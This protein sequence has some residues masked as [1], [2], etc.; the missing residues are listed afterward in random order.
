MRLIDAN[1]LTTH[2]YL[3]R[4]HAP[5]SSSS[6]ASSSGFWSCS[7]CAAHPGRPHRRSLA[8]LPSSAFC[9]YNTA[10]RRLLR[11]LRRER[12]T[13]PSCHQLPRSGRGGVR[14]APKRIGR[15]APLTHPAA[16]AREGHGRPARRTAG[17]RRR[18]CWL[19]GLRMVSRARTRRRRRKMEQDDTGSAG[20]SAAQQ[21]NASCR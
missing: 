3:D 17:S 16:H 8:F 11:R 18:L 19:L 14:P 6:S 15:G 2:Q 13:Y 10:G 4:T 7:S 20:R 5:L 1:R 9:A 21:R 12:E